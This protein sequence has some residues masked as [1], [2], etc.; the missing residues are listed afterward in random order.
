MPSNCPRRR[1]W[2]PGMAGKLKLGIPKGSLQDAT[3]ALFERAGWRIFANGRSYLPT[4]DD[5]ELECMLVRAQ[6]VWRYVDKGVLDAGLT[7]IDWVV[8]S[9]RDVASITSLTYSKQTRTKVRCVLAV[10]AGS[11]YQKI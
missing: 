3:I 9:G 4:V 8:E 2:R 7:G 11:P 5:N 1:R 10:P 6:E